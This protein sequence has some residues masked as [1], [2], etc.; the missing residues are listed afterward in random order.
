MIHPRRHSGRVGKILLVFFSMLLS[1]LAVEMLVRGLGLSP[2]VY[3][4]QAGRFRLSKNPLI[5]YEL[6]PHFESDVGG[7]ML[8]FRGKAN[9]LGFRD[10][11]HPVEKPQGVYRVLV[12]GDSIVQGLG[13]PSSDDIFTT[14]LERTLLE[15]GNDVEVLNFGVSGYNTLQEVETLR[16]KGLP[17][18]SDLIV[19][20]F[21]VN[22]TY[23]DCG[24]I[25]E[26]LGRAEL[27]RTATLGLPGMLR[28]SAL[29][30]LTSMILNRHRFN[31]GDSLGENRVEQA[32]ENLANLSRDFGF[33][34]L[35]V[36][37]PILAPRKYGSDNQLHQMVKML[38]ELNGFHYYDL[39][40]TMY[41]HAKRGKINL[42][43]LHPNADGHHLVGYELASQINT[44]FLRHQEGDTTPQ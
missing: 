12:L 19:L 5:G 20:V 36:W 42:D 6:V 37:F 31:L 26:Y 43:D 18:A 41:T 10:R 34:T 4:A 11:E 35:V 8:D 13:V 25:L 7:P 24:G 22:D 39:S 21:C 28:K 15:Q 3:T 23:L 32:F 16:E 40:D 1:L 29:V 27:Q 38:S 30:R 33:T 44:R 14:V 17:F 9:S 2:E